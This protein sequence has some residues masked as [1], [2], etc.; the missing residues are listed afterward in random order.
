[1]HT[2]HAKLDTTRPSVFFLVYTHTE[3][4]PP[5]LFSY[6]GSKGHKL[7][8]LHKHFHHHQEIRIFTF[9]APPSSCLFVCLL[10]ERKTQYLAYQVV[11]GSLM[12]QNKPGSPVFIYM[13]IV[14]RVAYIYIYICI[15]VMIRFL[16]L[17]LLHLCPIDTQ[18][19][20]S[21]R[22]MYWC[23]F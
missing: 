23:V 2:N 22:S 10:V 9:L 16:L 6:S 13:H 3:P 18:S 11:K 21:L 5:H 20:P 1:M 4:E 8:V 14:Y 15:A 19:V 12:D 17:L 7:S